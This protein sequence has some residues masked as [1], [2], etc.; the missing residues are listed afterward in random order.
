MIRPRRLGDLCA[1][2]VI[3]QLNAKLW[4]P[5]RCLP[6]IPNSAVA[7]RSLV[8]NRSEPLKKGTQWLAVSVWRP[9]RKLPGPATL[10]FLVDPERRSGRWYS[11]ANSGGVGSE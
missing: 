2:P 7:L 11:P 10:G 8:H 9:H 1:P 5:G 4:E 6:G 3:R